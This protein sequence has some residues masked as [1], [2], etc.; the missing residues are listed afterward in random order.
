[1]RKILV[2]VDGSD[3]SRRAVERLVGMLGW[4]KEGA[5][6]HLLTVHLPLPLAGRASSVLG[7]DVVEKYYA[8]EEAEAIKPACEILDR[9]GVAY[10]KHSAVGDIA[11]EIVKAG[12]KLG[13]DMIV[14]GTHG[15]GKVG[16]MVLGSV[17]QKVLAQ[18]NTPVLLI[19]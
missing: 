9:A 18:A 4:V 10:K 15:R 7:K 5:E 2:A 8:E 17:A 14:M 13:A 1:M 3:P 16:S 19:K 6:V 11:G 12:E